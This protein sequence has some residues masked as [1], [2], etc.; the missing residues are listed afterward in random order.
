MANFRV[1]RLIQAR[2]ALSLRPPLEVLRVCRPPEAPCQVSQALVA[3]Q[4]KYA[5]LQ[6]S[7]AEQRFQDQ[8]SLL[9]LKQDVEDAQTQACS[10]LLI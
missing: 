10:V 8:T 1:S 6:E 5:Q 3:V 7:S 2:G 9:S 4:M